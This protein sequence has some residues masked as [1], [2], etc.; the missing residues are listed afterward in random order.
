MRTSCIKAV[1]VFVPALAA[2]KSE[3][4]SLEGVGHTAG[5]DAEGFHYERAKDKGQ[6]ESG[7]QPFEG[8]CHFDDSVLA[9]RL[10]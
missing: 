5:G 9:N 2:T 10:I 4:I 6:Y 1:V 8:V 7:N 3:V